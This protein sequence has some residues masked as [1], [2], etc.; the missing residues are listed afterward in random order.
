MQ[1]AVPLERIG[2]PRR[3]ALW[4]LALVGA[5]AFGFVNVAQA[6]TLGAVEQRLDRLEK[7]TRELQRATDRSS[8]SSNSRDDVY[9]QLDRR[10]GALERT[11]ANLVSAQERDHRELATTVE[12]LQRMKR[13]V[14]ARLDSV[15]SQ[16]PPAPAAQSADVIAEA[17]E[18]PLDADARFTQAMDFAD[19]EDWPNAEFAFDTFIASYPSDAR[20]PEARYQLG[21][22]FE[23]QGKHAQAAQIFLDL[24]QGHP[25]APFAVPNLFALAEA[26][27]A[28]GPEN[29]EQA[30][31]VYSEIE[32]THGGTLSVDQRSQLLDRRLSLKCSK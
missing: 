4:A 18:A 16:P 15:E 31:D 32:V 9:L 13:D 23:G 10:L 3:W 25:D 11:V 2:P 29:T 1:I 17:P 28:I 26:L 8:R 12:Q 22:A 24:Y 6:Q 21:R 30:C 5:S 14:E 19:R 27:G 7:V 20:I